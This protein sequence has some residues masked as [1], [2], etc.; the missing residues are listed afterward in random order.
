M[1]S[2]NNVFLNGELHDEN[3]ITLPPRFHSKW[4]VTSNLKTQRVLWSTKTKHLGNGLPKI[5]TNLAGHGFSQSKSDHGWHFW[6]P[7]INDLQSV[8]TN[9]KPLKYFL[10]LEVVR[11]S[12][13]ISLCHDQY[14]LM[15]GC[16]PLDSLW[17]KSWSSLSEMGNC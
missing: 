7:I 6:Q 1:W 14:A 12:K 11:S 10:V 13:R 9:L 2:L 3:Y 5:S 16:Q 8:L 15:L 17:I 4:G